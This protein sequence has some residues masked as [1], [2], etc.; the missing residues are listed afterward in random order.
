MRMERN[1]PSLCGWSSILLAL[2]G[3]RRGTPSPPLR[4]SEKY[5]ITFNK[6]QALP[7]LHNPRESPGS[8]LLT[9]MTAFCFCGARTNYM[10]LNLIEKLQLG[11]EEEWK[12]LPVEYKISPTYLLAAVSFLGR[13]IIFG[14]K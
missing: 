11:A 1:S 6:W 10:H 4:V 14:G 13:I 2:G 8:C 7:S 3:Q 12:S 9:S 5:S